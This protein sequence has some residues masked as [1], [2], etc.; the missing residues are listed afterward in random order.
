MKIL[1]H[2]FFE[3]EKDYYQPINSRGASDH[4]YLQFESNIDRYKTL[5]LGG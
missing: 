2:L 1:D 3:D 4:T 5:P